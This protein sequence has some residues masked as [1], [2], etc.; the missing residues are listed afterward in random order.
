MN[1]V[2]NDMQDYSSDLD[3]AVV[4]DRSELF[5]VLD[6]VQDREPFV[7]ELEGDNGFKL[8]LG[9]GKEVGCVQHSPSNGDVPYLMALA[10]GDHEEEEYVEFMMGNTPS[11]I[12]KRNVLP[13]ETVKEIAAYFVETGERWPDV[14]WEEI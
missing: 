5:A 10:P 8:M 11:P 12:P 7:C 9:I 3:G 4:R 2:F 1:A 13:F 6:S 14:A